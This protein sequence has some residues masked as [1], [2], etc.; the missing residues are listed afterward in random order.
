[1]YY[2]ACYISKIIFCLQYCDKVA[3]LLIACDINNCDMVYNCIISQPH[4]H[5]HMVRVF[6]H[7]LCVAKKIVYISEC[8]HWTN[9]ISSWNINVTLKLE[10]KM[11]WF[12]KKTYYCI[13]F[14]FALR[15]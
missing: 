7:I 2:N 1:M 8:V 3:V 11:D 9:L 10:N 15:Y 14:V 4:L 13:F 6:I 12:K 5:L